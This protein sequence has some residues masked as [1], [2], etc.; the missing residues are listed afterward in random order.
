MDHRPDYIT[1]IKNYISTLPQG[2]TFQ[3]IPSNPYNW[4]SYLKITEDEPIL[5]PGFETRD[6]IH[7]KLLLTGTIN[8]EGLLMQWFACLGNQNWMQRFGSVRM[9]M[10]VPEAS[11]IKLLADPGLVTRGKCSI[12]RETFS[13]TK[14][15]AVADTKR[16]LKFPQSRLEKDS[17]LLYQESDVSGPKNP[18]ALLEINPKDHEVQ[19]MLSWDYVTKNLMILKR[20]PLSDSIRNLGPAADVFFLEHLP[21]DMLEKSVNKLTAE[22]F[23]EITRVFDLW[24]FKPDVLIDGLIDLV[25]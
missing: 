11:A 24:P 3:H 25:D 7:S 8:D 5:Q 12:V 17:P 19:D 9:L 15:L 16:L 22:E 1:H 13:D 4:K 18:L 21:R 20:K 10:W 23:I 6:H 2:H 14:I